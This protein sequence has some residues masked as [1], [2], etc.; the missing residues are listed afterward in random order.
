MHINKVTADQADQ[1]AEPTDGFRKRTGF[2]SSDNGSGN[3][4][5][6]G[7]GGMEGDGIGKNG[8]DGGR[9]FKL[10]NSIIIH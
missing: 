8:G 5:G 10:I 2:C 6:N 1:E 9:K 7:N 3:G 4:N